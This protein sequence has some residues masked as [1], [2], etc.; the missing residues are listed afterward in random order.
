[1]HHS[2]EFRSYIE[3][4]QYASLEG[5]RQDSQRT[6]RWFSKRHAVDRTHLGALNDI[7]TDRS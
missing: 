7:I 4:Q 1:M 3:F 5:G 2:P 6:L